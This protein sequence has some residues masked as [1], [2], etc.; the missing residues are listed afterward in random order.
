MNATNLQKIKKM[1]KKQQNKMINRKRKFNFH[2]CIKSH[3]YYS[4]FI[5]FISFHLNFSVLMTENDKK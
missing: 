4:K 2:F 3:K 1:Q 5:L